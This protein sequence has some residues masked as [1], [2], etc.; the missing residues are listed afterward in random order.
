MINSLALKS[1]SPVFTNLNAK[2]MLRDLVKIPPHTSSQ[3][4]ASKEAMPDSPA[5]GTRL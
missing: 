1:A 5:G 2:N 3:A 4:K